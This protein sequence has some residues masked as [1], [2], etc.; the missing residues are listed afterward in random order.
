[1]ATRGNEFLPLRTV[2]R[3]MGYHFYHVRRA[4][5]SVTFLLRACVYCVIGA[6]SMD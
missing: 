1:M 4:P 2:P 6:M 5:L 3:G